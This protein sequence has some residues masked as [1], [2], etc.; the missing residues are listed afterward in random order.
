VILQLTVATV[1]SLALNVA[2]LYKQPLFAIAAGFVYALLLW[3]L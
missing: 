2:F 3:K 1:G